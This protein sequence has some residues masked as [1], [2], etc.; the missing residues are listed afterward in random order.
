MSVLKKKYKM[1]QAACID[2]GKI[3]NVQFR[4]GEPTRKRCMHC[5]NVLNGLR[6]AMKTKRGIPL[7]NGIS[8]HEGYVI[9]LL[10]PNDPFFPMVTKTRYVKRSRLVVAKSLGRCLTSQEHV[11]HI[12]GDISDDRIEN[13]Q[14]LS[15]KEHS[16]L[17][18]KNGDFVLRNKKKALS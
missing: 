11:H 10:S 18:F 4:N 2:C 17:H 13:L 15:H 7:K 6:A 14:I 1:S 3:R 8:N 12:N 9:I 5:A 16:L